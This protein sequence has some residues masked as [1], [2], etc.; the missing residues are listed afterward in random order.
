MQNAQ[1]RAIDKALYKL[2][3]ILDSDTLDWHL[4]II[5]PYYKSFP[6]ISCSLWESRKM[7]Q[8]LLVLEV[9]KR[10]NKVHQSWHVST[11]ICVGLY[12]GYST[13]LVVA[14]A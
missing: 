11:K 7:H 8:K 1:R 4:S 2:S 14:L 13:F 12:N 5:L 3:L 10:K 9:A 6:Q